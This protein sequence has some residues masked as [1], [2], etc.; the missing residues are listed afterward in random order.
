MDCCKGSL[1][2][3]LL[4]GNYLVSTTLFVTVHSMLNWGP[5]GN[6]LEKAWLM[7]ERALDWTV[8]MLVVL[9]DLRNV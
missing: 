3:S 1:Q 6:C 2:M 9:R 4:N 8:L 5:I 7:L